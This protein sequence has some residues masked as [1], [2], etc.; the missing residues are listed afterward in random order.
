MTGD[1][2]LTQDV[3]KDEG[4]EKVWTWYNSQHKPLYLKK[5]LCKD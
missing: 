3:E 4:R 2:S 5:N 1:V